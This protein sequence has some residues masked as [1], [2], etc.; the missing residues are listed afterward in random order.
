[1]IRLYVLWRHYYFNIPIIS[2]QRLPCLVFMV[3]AALFSYKYRRPDFYYLLLLNHFYICKKWAA[4][5]RSAAGSSSFPVVSISVAELG[6]NLKYKTCFYL[7]SLQVPLG[8]RHKWKPERRESLTRSHSWLNLRM[9]LWWMNSSTDRNE[10]S[11]QTDWTWATNRWKYG[12][13][14]GGWRR[15][16]WWCASKLSPRTDDLWTWSW[17]AAHRKYAALYY[18]CCSASQGPSGRWHGLVFINVYTRFILLSH[19]RL[20]FYPV[21]AS[22]LILMVIKKRFAGRRFYPAGLQMRTGPSL[23]VGL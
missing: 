11:C 3:I 5:I 17:P 20:H 6:V 12:F 10:R 8:A 16:D 19:N 21:P 15:N 9:N 13:R 2:S 14:T 1:M 7:C 22:S 18:E 23:L 4:V